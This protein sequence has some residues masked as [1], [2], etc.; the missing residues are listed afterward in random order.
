VRELPG[1]HD[2]NARQRLALVSEYSPDAE[3]RL[4]SASTKGKA[5]SATP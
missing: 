4:V 2:V 1:A 3:V 5:V